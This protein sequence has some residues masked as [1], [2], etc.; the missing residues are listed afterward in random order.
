M[1]SVPVL[2]A[3]IFGTLD[4]GSV[5]T[6]H[7]GTSVFLLFGA[8]LTCIAWICGQI[9]MLR[10]HKRH[11]FGFHLTSVFLWLTCFVLKYA[12]L[13]FAYF[14]TRSIFV[15]RTILNYVVL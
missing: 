2:S 13:R 9:A 4:Q 3:F 14:T 11:T 15:C 10:V 8:P 12:T 6:L 5:G 1:D 7:G